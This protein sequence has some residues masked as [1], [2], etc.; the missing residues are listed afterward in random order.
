[1]PTPQ[2]RI[3]EETMNTKLFIFTGLVGCF[4]ALGTVAC[5]DSGTTSTSTGGG[6][7]GGSGTG[8][9]TTTASSTGGSG[10]GGGAPATCT[11]Y[12]TTI[13]AACSGGNA[14]YTTMDG[15]LKECA[16]FAQ[17][18][19][20]DVSGD[21][22][23]C[24]A[25]HAGVAAKPTDPAIHCVHAGPLGSGAGT[26]GAGCTSDHLSRCA[27]YCAINQEVCGTTAYATADECNTACMLADDSVDFNTGVTSV[28]GMNGA[29][30]KELECRT[31]HMSVAA[32]DAAS[33]DVHCDHTNFDNT[34]QCHIP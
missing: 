28:G 31:Y 20:G 21:T 26:A 18:M 1:M 13:M 14:Q 19:P 29:D 25:Y 5:G 23:E 33:A 8:G 10:S 27:A 32:Q 3:P 11:N 4:T 9:S 17:G 2:G 24:R 30:L 7:T 15:C 12:C 16:A 22:L 6:G 34:T